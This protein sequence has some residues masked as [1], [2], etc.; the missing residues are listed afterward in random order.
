MIPGTKDAALSPD[1]AST[2][3]SWTKLAQLY[4]GVVSSSE[5]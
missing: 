4:Q 1:I 5:G 2:Q 3:Q